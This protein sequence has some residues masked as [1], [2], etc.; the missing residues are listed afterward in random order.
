MLMAVFN[1]ISFSYWGDPY[2]NVEYKGKLYTRGSWSLIASIFRAIEEWKNILNPK[3]L[4][5]I[6][7]EELAI[8]LRGNIEIPLL[9]ERVKILNEL[10][11]ILLEKFDGKFSKII[12]KAN[13]NAIELLNIILDSFSSFQDSEYYKSRKIYFQ[14][15]AQALIEWIHSIFNG[16]GYGKLNNISSLTACADYIIPNILREIGILEYSKEIASKIDNKF[17]IDKWSLEEVEI[18][19]HTI[20]VVELIKEKLELKGIIA[21]ALNINDYL[22]TIGGNTKTPFHMTRTTSY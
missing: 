12:E 8:I 10:W 20:Q 11:N 7:K 9:E 19:S 16:K 17:I 3:F 14:K 4:S 21:S 2:W 5:T 18:R 15:R 22:W 13:F 6:S 1:S